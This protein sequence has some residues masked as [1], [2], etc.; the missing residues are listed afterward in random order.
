MT[1]Q[2]SISW[3]ASARVGCPQGEL[4]LATCSWSTLPNGELLLHLLL[5]LP[6]WSLPWISSPTFFSLQQSQC[7]IGDYWGASFTAHWSVQCPCPDCNLTLGHRSQHL[8]TGHPRSTPTLRA[9]DVYTTSYLPIHEHG[10]SPH[11]SKCPLISSNNISYIHNS[12]FLHLWTFVCVK[13]ASLFYFSALT[14]SRMIFSNSFGA[15][16]LL[17]H[18]SK[19]ASAC[20]AVTSQLG[21][22]WLRVVTLSN[23]SS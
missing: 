20:W 17:L 15:V 21:W 5:L 19:M 16:S 18:G 12:W 1:W 11:S 2:L 22:T 14:A 10:L 23:L 4:L 7:P 8:N 6:S 3:A 9:T 13:M